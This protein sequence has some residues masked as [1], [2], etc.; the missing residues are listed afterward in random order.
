[1][2][3]YNLDKILDEIFQEIDYIDDEDK[4]NIHK[5]T[6]SLS[7]YMNLPEVAIFEILFD[8]FKLGMDRTK[9]NLHIS[10]NQKLDKLFEE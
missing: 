2:K 3:N 10:I 9:K 7:E 8:I 5:Y 1:M 4:R 6:I